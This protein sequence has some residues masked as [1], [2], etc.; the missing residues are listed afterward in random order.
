MRRLLIITGIVVL[1]VIITIVL[2]RMRTKSFSP[3]ADVK[4]E[5]QGFKIEVFYNRP[6]KK[7]REI[8][9]GLVPYGEVW[10]TGANEATII[11]TTT[12]LLI[13]D[14][15]LKAGSYSLWTIPS[16]QN[17]TIIFNS[18][19]GQWGVKLIDGKAN[20]DEKRDV[21]KFEVPVFKHKKE[22]EQFTI[23]IEKI[24]D[25]NELNLMWD[26]TLVSIPFT[27]VWQSISQ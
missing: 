22:I 9:G 8:F 6:F 5:D 1:L 15:V 4:F 16:E 24:D 26:S 11:S 2:L 25:G 18:E 7:G 14:K 17:W 10:R 23:L 3:E 21:L 19:I 27:V 13:K 20:R 12:D